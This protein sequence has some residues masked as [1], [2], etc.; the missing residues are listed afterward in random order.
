MLRKYIND[1]YPLEQY[2]KEW[3]LTKEEANELNERKPKDG[4]T[5]THWLKK[6]KNDWLNKAE[7]TEL[8]EDP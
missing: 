5:W 4:S 8:E 3:V 2:L 7:N 1:A 6:M